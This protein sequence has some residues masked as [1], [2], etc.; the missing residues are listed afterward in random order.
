MVIKIKRSRNPLL[1]GSVILAVLLC[2]SQVLNQRLLILLC[3]VGFLAI[4]AVAAWQGRAVPVLLF[5]LPWSPLLKPDPDSLS[6]FTF[7]LIVVAIVSFLKKRFS[8]NPY[9][10]SIAVMLFLLT[11]ISLRIEENSPTASY[12]LFFFLLALFPTIIGELRQGVDFKMLTLYFSFGII[13]AALSAK[14]LVGFSA[15]ARYIDVY[16]WSVVTRYSGFYGDANFYSAHIS[17]AL[18]GTL[19]LFLHEEKGRSRNV[20]L[21]LSILLLYC[22]FLSASKA[23]FITIA[24]LAVF[25]TWKFVV[26]KGKAAQKMLL[27]GGIL[28][29]IAVVAGSGIFAEQWKVIIFRFQQSSTLSG[30]TT[31]RTDIWADYFETMIREPKLLLIGKGYINELILG[32]ASHNTVIQIVYQLGIIGAAFLLLWEYFFIRATWRFHGTKVD[33]LDA[34]VLFVGAFFPW[35]ALDLLFFDEFFLVQ[36]YVVAGLIATGKTIRAQKLS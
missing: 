24:L 11:L 25:W 14:W 26:M 31:G 18:A 20:Y 10:L 29:L 21:I 3:L 23:F 36:I 27:F 5:F 34:A 15:I 35:M 12:L 4:S 1:I 6:Y 28:I 16:S 22:G 8:T 7:A 9:C 17:A 13:M 32:K 2:V 30:I 33:L 19:L